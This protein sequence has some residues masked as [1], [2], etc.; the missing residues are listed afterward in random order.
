MSLQTQ[1]D[2]LLRAAVAAGDVPGAV[3]L[4]TNG[5]ETIYEGGFGERVLGGGP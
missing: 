5:Q 4:A 1:A 3:A 2:Q